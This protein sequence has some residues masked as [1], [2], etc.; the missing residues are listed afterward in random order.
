M[1]R[2][3]AIRALVKGGKSKEAKELVTEY[4]TKAGSRYDSIRADATRSDDYKRYELAVTARRLNNELTDKLVDMA[5]RVVNTDVEDAA[6]AFGTK[7]L[8]GDAA[9]LI[10]SRRDAGDRVAEVSNKED[11]MSLLTRA[12]RSGDEVLAR[13]A[14]ERA[15]ELQ[16]ADVVNKFLE[17]RPELDASVERL[18]NSARADAGGAGME[19]TLALTGLKPGEFASWGMVDDAVSKGEPGSDTSM[20]TYSRS[21]FSGA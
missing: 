16:Y 8:S 18:W 19:F 13:A 20:S 14:A 17:S 5:A 6:R 10:I 2:Q 12:T 9:S 15:V 1:N 3:E 7:G 11:L 4:V 21:L